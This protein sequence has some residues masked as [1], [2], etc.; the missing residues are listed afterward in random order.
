MAGL[1]ANVI[2]PSLLLPLVWPWILLHGAFIL[3][4][5]TLVAFAVFMNATI[6]LALIFQTNKALIRRC[7]STR[8]PPFSSRVRFE[9]R[10]SCL[11][12]HIVLI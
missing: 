6:A 4:R 10:F 8:L 5:F 2:A 3:S 1:L 7:A 12:M 9:A 11:L